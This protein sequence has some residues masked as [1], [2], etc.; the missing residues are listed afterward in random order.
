[1]LFQ[2]VH[3]HLTE[4]SLSSLLWLGAWLWRLELEAAGPLRLQKNL[5]CLHYGQ[6]LQKSGLSLFV[7]IRSLNPL[8]LFNLHH[9]LLT[10][11]FLELLAS[12]LCHLQI[13]NSEHGLLIF[14]LCSIHWHQLNLFNANL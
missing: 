11:H 8:N 9:S 7:L 3:F 1:M 14:K 5:A 6:R 10:L 12:E 4:D 13:S 2:L